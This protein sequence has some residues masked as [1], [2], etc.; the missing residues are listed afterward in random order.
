MEEK[1][2]PKLLVSRGEAEQKIQE[3]IDKGQQLHD[4]QI[5]SKI[6]LDKAEAEF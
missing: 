5:G 4:R 1:I 6:E 2:L 3:R